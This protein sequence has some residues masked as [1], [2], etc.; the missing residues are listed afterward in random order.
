MPWPSV[1]CKISLPKYESFSLLSCSLIFP[2]KLLYFIKKL[3]NSSVVE[4]SGHKTSYF[5]RRERRNDCVLS[6]LGYNDMSAKET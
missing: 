5:S 1:F 3:L 2:A 6:S 4:Y